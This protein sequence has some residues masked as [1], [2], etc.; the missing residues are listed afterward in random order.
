MKDNF[1]QK[2]S[3]NIQTAEVENKNYHGFNM[4]YEINCG[5]KEFQVEEL[6]VFHIIIE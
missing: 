5:E 2:N 4:D 3:L 1:F 6:E